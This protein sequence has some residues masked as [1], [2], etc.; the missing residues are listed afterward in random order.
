VSYEIIIQ[1]EALQDIQAAYAWYEEQLPG[2]GEDFLSELNTFLEKLRKNPQH[3]SFT[4][5]DFRDVRLKRFPYLIV[6]RIVQPNVYINS[7]K[8]SKRK[9]QK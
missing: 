2:L 8:H 7:V 3:Y 5:D 4:F 1:H 6:F 9:P